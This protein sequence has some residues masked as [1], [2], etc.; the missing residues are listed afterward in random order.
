METSHHHRLIHR[1]HH[2][3]HHHISIYIGLFILIT[4]FCVWYFQACNDS[5]YMWMYYTYHGQYLIGVWLILNGIIKTESNKKLRIYV[6]IPFSGFFSSIFF[7]FIAGNILE[8][9]GLRYFH[10]NYDMIKTIDDY[11]KVNIVVIFIIIGVI[12]CGIYYLSTLM[13]QR[14]LR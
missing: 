8:Q 4:G 12:G 3:R 5:I 7:L 6:L 13:R 9:I 1:H 10:D 14:G 2:H 11:L